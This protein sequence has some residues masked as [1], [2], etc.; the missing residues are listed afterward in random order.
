MTP[1]L[2]SFSLFAPGFDRAV[3]VTH[4]RDAPRLRAINLEYV[5][6]MSWELPWSQLTRLRM[7]ISDYRGP[8]NPDGFMRVLSQCTSLEHL[9]LDFVFSETRVLT[10][11][12]EPAIVP[13]LRCL[14]IDFKHARDTVFQTFL[15]NFQTPC[16]HTLIIHPG[17]YLHDD[18]PQS[19][20]LWAY[21]TDELQAV[22]L[23]F[24]G[25]CKGTLR[26][27]EVQELAESESLFR[28]VFQTLRNLTSLTLPTDAF[29]PS[30]VDFLTL[31]PQSA[32]AEEG[33]TDIVV[34]GPLPYLADLSIQASEFRSKR[35]AEIHA[36]LRRTLLFDNLADM[37]ESR[38]R[39][40][41][42]AIYRYG[43]GAELLNSGERIRSRLRA[44]RLSEWHWTRMAED[45]GEAHARFEAMRREGL[46][47]EV[48]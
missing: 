8:V 34:E 46:H 47:D 26:K 33:S 11:P 7:T 22:F 43:P 18:P 1:L 41:P 15:D 31:R 6:P 25:S 13:S 45:Y 12:I 2:H 19:V 38:W 24:L 40:T 4:F 39:L 17:W 37:V 48:Q 30:I 29:T 23:K 16:L 36:G 44:F 5:L 21:H 32:L 35:M 9:R 20:G 10:I 3:T 42:G 14:Q 27:L 28:T